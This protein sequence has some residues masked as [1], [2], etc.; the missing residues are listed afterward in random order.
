MI[1]HAHSQADEGAGHWDTRKRAP[2]KGWA[3]S[4]Y[5]I[6]VAAVPE[7]YDDDDNTI[8]GTPYWIRLE[9]IT[10]NDV[11]P[12]DTWDAVLDAID[13]QCKR[14]DAERRQVAAATPPSPPRRPRGRRH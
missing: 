8:E 1:G 12:R 14:E 6:E 9:D 5:H 2:F 4:A 10:Q 13:E 3:G 7:E 11:L